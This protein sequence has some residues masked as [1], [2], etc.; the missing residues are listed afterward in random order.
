MPRRLLVW[1][2]VLL[3]GAPSCSS[4]RQHSTQR[5]VA[6]QPGWVLVEDVPLLKQKELSDCGAAALGMIL[7]YWAKPVTVDALNKTL[8]PNKERGIKAGALRDLARSY[9]LEAFLIQGKL[10]DL[11][12][13]LKLGRPVLVGLIKDQQKSKFSHYEVVVG[14]NRPEGRVATLDPD[15]GWREEDLPT[16]LSQWKAASYL[17][18][19]VFPLGG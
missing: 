16:F 12:E 14:L 2:I 15:K 17:T 19:V 13:E 3:W 1:G 4:L 18:L 7:S 11:E 9:G 5:A 10:Q 6:R 8:K